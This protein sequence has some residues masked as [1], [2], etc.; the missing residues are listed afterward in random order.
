VKDLTNAFGLL[1]LNPEDY[2]LLLPLLKQV[3]DAARTLKD[4]NE[5]EY[6]HRLHQFQVI[7]REVTERLHQLD[8]ISCLK[9]E[10][11]DKKFWA[12]VD[13]KELVK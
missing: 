2:E 9:E 10:K 11:E 3:I 4:D 6:S 8:L 7:M 1:K 5:I 12:T 13:L